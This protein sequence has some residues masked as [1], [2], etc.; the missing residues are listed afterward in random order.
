MYTSNC[1]N[2]AGRDGLEK[3]ISAPFMKQSLTLTYL[4]AF[5]KDGDS[6]TSSSEPA[7]KPSSQDPSENSS[8]GKGSK[9]SGDER[10]GEREKL[11][12]VFRYTCVLCTAHPI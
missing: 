5:H 10:K 4:F 11:I 9:V 12:A 2:F 6:R 7:V 8:G 1:S 3:S